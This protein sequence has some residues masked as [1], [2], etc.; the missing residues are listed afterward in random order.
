MHFIYVPIL[1]LEKESVFPFL[2]LSTIQ[3]NF[4]YHFYN[5]CGIYLLD[6]LVVECRIRV[7]EV[8]DSISSQGPHNK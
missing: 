4:W 5:I 2:M 7:R 8:P 6:S 1:I 3:G